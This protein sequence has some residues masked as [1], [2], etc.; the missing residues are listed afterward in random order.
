ML[1]IEGENRLGCDLGLLSEVVRSKQAQ[2]CLVLC[3]IW[4]TTYEIFRFIEAC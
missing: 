4:K 2:V 1:L 3:L